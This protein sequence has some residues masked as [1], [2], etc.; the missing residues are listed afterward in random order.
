MILIFSFRKKYATNGIKSGIMEISTAQ[1]EE[2]IYCNECVSPIKYKNGSK[3]AKIKNAGRSFFFGNCNFR[4]A[5]RQTN[6]IIDEKSNRK[7]IIVIGV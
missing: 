3:N 2:S 7:K 4:S 5:A 1:V 6:K